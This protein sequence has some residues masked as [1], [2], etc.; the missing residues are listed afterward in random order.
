MGHTPQNQKKNSTIRVFILP[1][2]S[3]VNDINTGSCPNLRFLNSDAAASMVEQL[4]II[5][6]PFLDLPA[7]IC[8]MSDT[9]RPSLSG[10]SIQR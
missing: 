4:E 9:K 7:E 8:Y 2:F 6:T 3:E 5:L 10:K 1:A